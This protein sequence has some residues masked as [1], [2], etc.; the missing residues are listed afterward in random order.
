MR[1]RREVSAQALRSFAAR[2]R[3]WWLIYA[4]CLG[5]LVLVIGAAV[6]FAWFTGEA[7]NA[8]LKVAA[9]AA[10]ALPRAPLS[11]QLSVAWKTTDTTALG[12]P[13]QGGTVVTYSAHTVTGRNAR[14]GAAMWTYTRSNAT[15]CQ[16]GQEQGKTI[17]LF[18]RD[19][20]CDE[21]S[22]FYTNTGKRAWQRTLDENMTP[23]QGRGSVIVLPDT[24]FVWTPAVIYAVGVSSAPCKPEIGS[25]CGADQWSYVA[26]VGCRLRSVVP[27]ALGV[28]ISQR[29]ADGDSLLLRERYQS[30]DDGNDRIIW[31][32]RSTSAVPIGADYF[33]GALDPGTGRLSVYNHASGKV[34]YT[35]TLRPVPQLGARIQQLSLP[36]WDLIQIGGTCYAFA[37][38]GGALKWAASTPTLPGL[39]PD[40]GRIVYEPSAN[41]VSVLSASTGKPTRTLPGPSAAGASYLTPMGSGFLVSGLS[42]SGTTAL[43]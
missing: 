43:R 22:A 28:L 12:Q 10:P 34:Q 21:L 38:S 8:H 3:R 15:V 32:A 25:E 27:G 9:Q 29:C 7:A 42:G 14:T 36:Q 37:V 39:D 4:A 19:G 1:D 40:D 30:A 17:A 5:V 35:I 13:F 26:K 24:F 31:S 11:G 6:A 18:D 33:I 16:V 23:V 41:G 2:R 20:S